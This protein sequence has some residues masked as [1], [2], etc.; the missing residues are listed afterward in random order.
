MTTT[1]PTTTDEDVSVEPE[2][3]WLNLADMQPHP[4][5]PRANLGDLSELT[6][7]IRSHGIIEPVVVL[8]ANDEGVYLIVA[9]RRRHAAGLKAGITDV[10]A[11]VRPM[12]TV[13]VI[14][15]G[16][17]EN[18]NPHRPHPVRGSAGDRAAH[19]AGRGRYPS[20]ALP[21]N[22]PLAG[23]GAV[24]HGGHDPPGPMAGGAR[25][26]RTLARRSGGGSIGGR[27]RP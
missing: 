3:C 22:R 20:K 16:L 2:L 19:V 15:A 4:D 27:P 7:S 26:G 18:G 8:P 11:V 9:G 10:P 23:L 12:S 21:P 5:N 24:A 1:A 13:E 25:Q 17:S 6:R 14:E